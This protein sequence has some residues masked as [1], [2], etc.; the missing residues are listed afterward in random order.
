VSG[1]DGESVYVNDVR[2]FMTMIGNDGG[3]LNLTVL[4][5]NRGVIDNGEIGTGI[6]HTLEGSIDVS[7][8]ILVE[9]RKPT[10][11][12]SNMRYLWPQAHLSHTTQL[13]DKRPNLLIR[14]S[15]RPPKMAPTSHI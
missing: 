12:R 2:Q 9:R 7:R 6:N 8:S 1:Y 11:P 15:P 4:K 5:V 10:K 3:S 14:I 13:V